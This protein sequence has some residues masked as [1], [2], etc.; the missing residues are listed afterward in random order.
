MHKIT[1][2]LD[3]REQKFA[4]MVADG[5][6]PPTSLDTYRRA[7]KDHVRPALGEIRIG[8]ATRLASTK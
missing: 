2:L 1:H 4:E 8:E 7:I 3:L 5:Q 6:R